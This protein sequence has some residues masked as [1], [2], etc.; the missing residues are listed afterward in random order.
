MAIRAP[1]PRFGAS[2]VLRLKVTGGA[3]PPVALDMDVPPEELTR[4]LAGEACLP[5]EVFQQL[6][7]TLFDSITGDVPR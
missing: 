7:E 6:G 4:W 5:D 1:G 2:T 3:R